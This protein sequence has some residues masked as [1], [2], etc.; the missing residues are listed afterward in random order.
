MKALF[1]HAPLGACLVDA[2][3]RIREVNPAAMPMFGDIAGG[4][5]GRDFGEIMHVSVGGP[6]RRRGGARIFRHVLAS[7][8]PYIAPEWAEKR[9]DR[10]VVEHYEWRVDRIPLP[11]GRNGMVCYFRDVSVQVQARKAIEDSH[12]ALREADRRKNEFLA[13]LSH[14]LRNPLAPMRNALHVMRYHGHDT[15]AVAP[16]RDIIERQLNSLVRLIDDLLEMSRITSGWLELKREHVE[17][18]AVVRNAVETSEPVVQAGHHQLDI[19]LPGEALWIEGDPIRLSQILSNLLNNA[20][21][22]TPDGGLIS[23]AAR[24]DG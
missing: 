9:R 11:D 2:D 6:T 17:L 16:A 23:L 8:E 12:E 1:D 10:G 5:I 3:F 19:S 15:A 18:S 24:R 13:T 21:K 14:E 22:Y 7:G 4:L 20:A